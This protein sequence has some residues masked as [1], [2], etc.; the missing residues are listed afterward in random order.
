MGSQMGKI[1][2][3]DTYKGDS[4]DSLQRSMQKEQDYGTQQ[5]DP[6][7]LVDTFLEDDA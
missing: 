3:S 1:P 6:T 5:F 7:G 2:E 4:Y